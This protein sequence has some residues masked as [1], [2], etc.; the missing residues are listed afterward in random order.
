MK[1]A[2]TAT[3]RFLGVF[4]AFAGAGWQALKLFTIPV[5]HPLSNQQAVI[6]FAQRHNA[7]IQLSRMTERDLAELSEQ[8]CEALIVAS[9]D[10]KI[11]DWRPYL[12]YAV[13]FHSSPLPDGRG[14]YPVS[15][16]ILENRP[17]WGVTCHQITPKIDQG[18]IIAV[19]NFPLQSDECHES[20]DLKIQLAAKR[21]A[22]RV[23]QNFAPLWDQAQPQQP[24]HYWPKTAFQ[25]RN[26][27]FK[28]PV[29]A[30]LRHIRAFGST[31][32]IALLN[33]NGFVVKRAVGWLESHQFPAGQIVHAFNKTLVVTA[34]DGY[35]GLLDCDLLPPHIAANALQTAKA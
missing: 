12:R 11:H 8:G 24:G 22:G 21:L 31:E 5:T 7:A 20:L 26:I 35:I 16:A 17:Y 13:N 27:N 10:W 14:P 34:S 32:S 19:E 18:P 15:R 30:I 29:A 4:E 1:F 9:Y 28:Q 23:A 6:A 25:E 33:N 2:I 3:D